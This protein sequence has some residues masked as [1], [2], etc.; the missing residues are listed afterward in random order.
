MNQFL[1][2][3]IVLRL[4]FFYNRIPYVTVRKSKFRRFYYIL[5]TLYTRYL[6]IGN[7]NGMI[8]TTKKLQICRN[9]IKLTPIG[10]YWVKR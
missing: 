5:F 6:G 7:Y 10:N 9:I 3:I 4:F 2:C 1:D 8:M